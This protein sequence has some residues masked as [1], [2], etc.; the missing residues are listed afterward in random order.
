[1]CGKKAQLFTMK[2]DIKTLTGKTI[3]LDVEPSDT[4][5]AI[6]EKIHATEG[7]P[8]DQQILIFFG[9]QLEDNKTLS[10]CN[11]QNESTLHL[12][13]R[14][15]GGGMSQFHIEDGVVRV[16]SK[17]HTKSVT[18]QTLHFRA[19]QKRF[20]RVRST[21]MRAW[22]YGP[23]MARVIGASIMF[24]ASLATSTFVAPTAVGALNRK[25]AL[26]ARCM[27]NSTSPCSKSTL[28]R[29][30]LELGS[31]MS[32]VLGNSIRTRLIREVNGT[33]K[34]KEPENTKPNF[35]EMP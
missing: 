4:I 26:V 21:I 30:W 20:N 33:M 1:M 12:I 15:R 8:E 6:K 10:D 24:I 28:P 17:D 23:M 9:E 16:S 31:A 22:Y 34:T 32:T 14:F 19:S 25:L 27:A 3:T 13:L 5:D 29:W 18:T 35:S 11:V 2:I 7:I